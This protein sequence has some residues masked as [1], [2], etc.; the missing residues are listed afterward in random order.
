MHPISTRLRKGGCPIHSHRKSR[1]NH[2]LDRRR[3][4]SC[5]RRLRRRPQRAESDGLPH[6][7]PERP[8]RCG[9]GA[10]RPHGGDGNGG[11]GRHHLRMPSQGGRGRDAGRVRMGLRRPDGGVERPQRRQIG[12]YYG[13]PATW[14]SMDGSKLTATQVAVAPA[15][16]GNIP[17]QLVKANPAMGSGAMS[18]VTHIQRVA[19]HGGV[20]PGSALRCCQRR[21]AP[22]GAL[23]GRLHLL[24]SG[25]K[26]TREHAQPSSSR[27]SAHR[28]WYSR[29]SR[30]IT[31]SES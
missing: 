27:P 16:S 31:M 29:S 11:R 21:P 30:L 3:V 2:A 6:L 14:E 25:L 24:E 18:G 10:C 1:E 22:D 28:A 13:P 17:L 4:P 15:G 19:T 7:L 12:K 23:P 20:A 5:T 8:A 9:E 26:A